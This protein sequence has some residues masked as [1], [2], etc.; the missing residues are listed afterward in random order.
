MCLAGFQS[1][2]KGGI[3][4]GDERGM[5]LSDVLLEWLPGGAELPGS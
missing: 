3:W 1:A 5:R 4:E 2:G